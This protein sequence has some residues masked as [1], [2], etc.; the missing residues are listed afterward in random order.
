MQNRSNNER[1]FLLVE[2]C[3]GVLLLVL[4]SQSIY[5]FV[6]FY[7]ETLKLEQQSEEKYEQWIRVER[8]SETRKW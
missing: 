3:V 5:V 4:L 6:F 1:G 8:L 2:V 7:G